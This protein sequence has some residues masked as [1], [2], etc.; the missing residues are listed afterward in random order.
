M[1]YNK[2][3]GW[4]GTAANDEAWRSAL[5]FFSVYF[6]LSS[7]LLSPFFLFFPSRVLL[8]SPYQGLP[9][10]V[11]FVR[12]VDCHQPTSPPISAALPL[13][14]FASTFFFKIRVASLL[15]SILARP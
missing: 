6:F 7:S 14:P 10:L 13:K 8:L 4:H 3:A 2:P 1:A 5:S 12:N 15:Y 11:P 9:I